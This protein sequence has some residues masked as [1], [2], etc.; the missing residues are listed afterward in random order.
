MLPHVILHNAVSVDGRIDWFAADVRKY[1]ELVAF[2]KED[3]TLA[4][5][6]TML[7][8]YP[9][10]RITPDDEEAF[11]H[12]KPKPEDTR[13]L[14]VVPD[15]RGRIRHILHVLRHEPYWRDTII[16]V[17]GS[18][19]KTYLDYLKSKNILF[20]QAGKEH[21]DYKAALEELNARYGVKV[22]RVDSGGI[23]NGVLLRAG[24]VNEVSLLVH[25]FLVG[26]TSPRSMYQAQDLIAANGVIRLKL[27]HLEQMENELIWLR[28]TVK[29]TV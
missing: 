20:I 24:L 4:G 14:L 6:E 16:L 23:L 25:P 19:P 13:A 28:Y 21:V 10:E 5:T 7:R 2:W 12:T 8:A 3:A 17:S 22:V 1:Y 9:E 11:E 15:S 29:G 26:G 27:T 18:T